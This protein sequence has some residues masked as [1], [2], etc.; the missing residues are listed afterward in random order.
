M[1]ASERRNVQEQLRYS[2]RMRTALFITNTILRYSLQSAVSC[3]VTV[4]SYVQL[5]RLCV[6]VTKRRLH[7]MRV[8]R[9]TFLSAFKKMVSPAD[10][11]L[12]NL[13][14]NYTALK[15]VW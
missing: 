15:D 6:V 7:S 3:K 12:T 2:R 4:I 1:A 9:I 11:A 10:E 13:Q 5:V 8:A 14:K